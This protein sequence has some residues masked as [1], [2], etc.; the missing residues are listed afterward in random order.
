VVCTA[1]LIGF[2][3]VMPGAGSAC[4][5]SL[6]DVVRGLNS[7]LNPSDARRLEQ[8]AYQN[9]RWD[10]QRYWHDYR[11]GLAYSHPN[12]RNYARDQWRHSARGG[13]GDWDEY[14]DRGYGSPRPDY[15]GDRYYRYDQ[16]Q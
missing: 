10:E 11:A 13:Y 4:A 8:Q 3:A 7:V 9:G 5:Q 15:P 14:G 2:L 1:G 16:R 12:Q 6:N